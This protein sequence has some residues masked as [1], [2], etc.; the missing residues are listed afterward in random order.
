[1]KADLVEE[2]LKCAFRVH[3]ELG[4]GLLE[5]AY[6]LCLGVELRSEG[7]ECREEV[8]IPI[9]YRGMSFD[10]GYRA[11]LIVMDEVLLELKAVERFHPIHYAQAISYLKHARLK[12]G[13][14]INFN[15]AHLRDGI[16]R[17][18]PKPKAI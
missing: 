2:V 14:L 3:S 9:R 15:T 13:L 1:V 11:D 12:T 4:P 8:P 17:V 10:C 18:W 7:L 6:R 16:R 5:S